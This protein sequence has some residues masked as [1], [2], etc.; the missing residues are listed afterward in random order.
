MV[1]PVLDIREL[2]I[3]FETRRKRHVLFERIN[4][5]AL[6]GEFIALIGPNGIGKSTLLKTLMHIL[7]P[8]K[9]RINLYQK[10]LMEYSRQ[11]RSHE[12]SFMS[13]EMITAGHLSVENLV[14]LGRIPHTNWIGTLAADDRAKIE[15]AI[16]KAKLNH[17]RHQNIGEISD[18]ERQRAMIARSIAQDTRMLILDEPTAYLDLPGRFEMLN[19]LKNLAKEEG[20]TI[21]F[22][23][24]DLNLV[25]HEVDKIWMMTDRRFEQGAPEDLMIQNAFASLFPQEWMKINPSDGR[26]IFPRHYEHTVQ[27]EGMEELMFWTRNALE[28]KGFRVVHDAMCDLK[29]NAGSDM[30]GYFWE[31]SAAGHEAER[32][33]SLYSL[34]SAIQHLY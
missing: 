19:L 13:T 34:L 22:S 12:M 31:F 26:F 23:T 14:A 33:R 8:L 9:G 18:G 4:A 28:R 5:S 29:V 16:N 17:I 2:S 3:G 11:E 30:E 15:W 21:L 20:K 32:F 24:H 6:R 10:S 7:K 27:L 1:E 25:V